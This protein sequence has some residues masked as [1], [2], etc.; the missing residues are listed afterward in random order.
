MISVKRIKEV[1]KALAEER[2]YVR[3]Y[4]VVSDS[5]I[6]DNDEGFIVRVEDDLVVLKTV[7]DVFV[8]VSNVLIY[9]IEELK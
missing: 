2:K 8:Y 9:K 7:D 6:A 4:Y 1:L 3:I 5:G